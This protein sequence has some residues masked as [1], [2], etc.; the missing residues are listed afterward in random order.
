MSPSIVSLEHGSNGLLTRQKF[1]A[2][3][4]HAL[5]LTYFSYL[6]LSA[7]RDVII[8]SSTH[9]GQDGAFFISGHTGSN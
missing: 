2:L 4:K 6:Q 7:D 3:L 9:A 5:R 1:T 8:V